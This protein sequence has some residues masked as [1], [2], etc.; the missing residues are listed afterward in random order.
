MAVIVVGGENPKA[1]VN[2][3]SCSFLVLASLEPEQDTTNMAAII[4]SNAEAIFIF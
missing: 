3:P 1:L 2:S 4:K